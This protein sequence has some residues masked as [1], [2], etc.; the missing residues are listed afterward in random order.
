MCCQCFSMALCNQFLLLSSVSIPQE[1]LLSYFPK[2][3]IGYAYMPQNVTSNHVKNIIAEKQLC[4]GNLVPV[5][6]QNVYTQSFSALFQKQSF[7]Y[8]SSRSH[9][10]GTEQKQMS[11]DFGGK[12]FSFT[13]GELASIIERFCY[14][15]RARPT[16]AFLWSGQALYSWLLKLNILNLMSLKSTMEASEIKLRQVHYTNSA[17]IGLYYS[18][19]LLDQQLL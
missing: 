12:P 3:F 5:K 19:V 6:W 8:K 11:G 15:S 4:I 7:G 2:V 18:Q 1:Y 17:W 16:C 10:L 13:V 9:Q 14:Q